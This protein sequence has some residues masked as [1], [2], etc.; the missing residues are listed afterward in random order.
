MKT[1]SVA[2]F[3]AALALTVGS[4]LPAAAQVAPSPHVD[5]P[6]TSPV[7]P[8]PRK[9]TPVVS[10]SLEPNQPA[11]GYQGS[12]TGDQSSADKS[13]TLRKGGGCTG[14]SYSS[15]VAQYGLNTVDLW[16]YGSVYSNYTSPVIPEVGQVPTVDQLPQA[17]MYFVMCNGVATA[18]GYVLPRPAAPAPPPIT[19]VAQRV[20]GEIPLPGVSIGLAPEDHGLTGLN[21]T[22]WVMGMPPGGVF[23]ASTTALGA[24][25]DVEARPT[26]FVWDFGDG[27]GVVATTSPGVAYPGDGPTAI[28]HLYEAKNLGYTLT[29]TFVLDVRYRVN[30]GAWT[31]LG[32]VQRPISRVY[33]VIE[34]RS[35]VTARG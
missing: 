31:E 16:L 32:P 27:T 25:I 19:A 30:G 24:T 21:Q 10:A 12:L 20:A 17:S 8:D 7:P 28:H 13:G 33:P 4:A 6:A 23:T 5:E 29:L 34:I 18:Y 2:A 1:S 15:A 3:V 35:I 11:V 22:Y 26:S 9:T 14:L